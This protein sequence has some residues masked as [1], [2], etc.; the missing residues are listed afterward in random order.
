MSIRPIII[1]YMLCVCTDTHLPLPGPPNHRTWV[2]QSFTLM[3]PRSQHRVLLV[4][5]SIDNRPAPDFSSTNNNFLRSA[6]A[7]SSDSEMFIVWLSSFRRMCESGR[8]A[9]THRMWASP[10]SCIGHGRNMLD[11][12]QACGRMDWRLGG[13][14]KMTSRSP[15]MM[16]LRDIYRAEG[17]I[18]F[19]SPVSLFD[20]CGYWRGPWI[21]A[22]C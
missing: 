14:C 19:S 1:F 21:V 3:L 22:L 5:M 4:F 20:E 2:C 18:Y 7:T 11:N 6:S 16:R 15:S 17:F 13:I 12:W 9:L 10:L 8:M